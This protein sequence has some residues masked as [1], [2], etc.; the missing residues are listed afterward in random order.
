MRKPASERYLLTARTTYWYIRTRPN[1]VTS[2]CGR[3]FIRAFCV[4]YRLGHCRD[5]QFIIETI[6]HSIPWNSTN[7]GKCIF[8]FCRRALSISVISFREFPP[9]PKSRLEDKCKF[10]NVKMLNFML[11]R[12][13]VFNRKHKILKGFVIASAMIAMRLYEEICFLAGK[14]WENRQSASCFV[15]LVI[16]RINKSCY[17]IIVSRFT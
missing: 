15:S 10:S 6:A 9:T 2:L 7:I 3:H 4:F 5:F 12:I 1:W 11:C 17:Y 14:I 13:L 8:I 16:S